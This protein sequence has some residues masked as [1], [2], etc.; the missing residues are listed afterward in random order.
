MLESAIRKARDLGAR[1]MVL[2]SHREIMA[3]AVKLY[4]SRG[5]YEIP[6][7]TDLATK[8]PGVIAMELALT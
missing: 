8:V 3:R 1:T 7:Y 6:D 5:F 4:R 2:E